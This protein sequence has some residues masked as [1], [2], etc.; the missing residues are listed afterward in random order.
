MI[1]IF[2]K[3]FV[4]LHQYTQSTVTFFLF[5]E[6]LLKNFKRGGGIISKT[7]E[8]YTHTPLFN[9]SSNI[10]WSTPEYTDP[11]YM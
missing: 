6:N 5:K 4:R 10:L 2:L 1:E 11:R 9:F 8:E 7:I 3:C